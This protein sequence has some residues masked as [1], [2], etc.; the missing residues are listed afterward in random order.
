[1]TFLDITGQLDAMKKVNPVYDKGTIPAATYA[2]PADVPTI[3]VPNVLLVRSDFAAGNACAITKLIFDKKDDLVKVHP[4][5]KE[6]S[7]DT[8]SKTDPVPLHPGAKQALGA[9]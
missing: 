4:A 1:V 9:G 6:L 8:A 5:A 3:V 2:L 7:R